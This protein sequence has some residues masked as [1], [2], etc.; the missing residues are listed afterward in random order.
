MDRLG[1]LSRIA[2]IAL[3]VIAT[4]FALDRMESV[5]A[6]IM[7][8]LVAGVVLSPMSDLW[9]R[10]GFPPAFAALSSLFLALLLIGGLG[11]VFHPLIDQLVD[12]APKVLSDMQDV[13]KAVRGIARGLEDMS[14][15]VSGAV[16]SPAIA[17][18][19]APAQPDDVM[20]MPT[21]ADALMLAPA[22]LAQV[23]IFAGALFFFLLTRNDIYDWSARRLSKPS[24]RAITATRL[25][26]AET[27]VAKYFLT[28]TIINAGLGLATAAALQL[29]GMPGAILWGMVAFLLN[30]V[31][32]IGPAGVVISLLFAGVAAFD[33][34][35]AV[36]P[37]L[38]FATLNATEGQFVTPALVGRHMELNPLLVFLALVFGIW[39]WGPIGGIVAIPML[40]WVLVLNNG[41][42]SPATPVAAAAE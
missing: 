20:P 12:A 30:Y 38:A 8:A 32:Y 25:R 16:V 34:I 18:T 35:H 21:V 26:E 41:L 11:L 40:L 13:I 24:N 33:G 31:L 2:M 14:N 29:L 6:P 9:E 4:V 17:A 3:G 42:K 15:D 37:A 28:I 19:E 36:L 22:V 1:T 27:R 7:L 5:I 39:L 23:L 10:G